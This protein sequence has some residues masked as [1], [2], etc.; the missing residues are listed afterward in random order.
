MKLQTV[1]YTQKTGW[2][3]SFRL[4]AQLDSERTLII[5]FG[6]PSFI[7]EFR[8]FDE[9]R[10]IFPKSIKIGCSGAGEI[11]GAHVIDESLSIAVIK[12]E[13]SNIK[14]ITL[15]IHEMSGSY[16]VGRE[17]ALQLNKPDLAGIFVLSDGLL[18]NGSALVNG[19]NS[20][21]P[22]KITTG[23]LAGDGSRFKE[24]WIVKNGKP[25]FGYVSAVGFYG[26]SIKIGYGSNAGWDIFGPERLVT[27]S[28]G[29]ILYELDG[30]P[31]L[32]LYKEYLGEKVAGLPATAL[33]FPL[34]IRSNE[35]D[36]IKIVRT[37]LAID[38]AHQ[39]MIF[40]GDI[41]EGS[42]AQLMHANFDRLIEGA[43]NT[44]KEIQ[45]EN[46][47]GKYSPSLVIAISCFGRRLVLGERTEEEVESIFNQL[48]SETRQIGFYSYGEISPHGF[49]KS[50]ELH[51]QTMTL[52]LI[53]EDISI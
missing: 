20:V 21:A 29:N 19:I 30:A 11:F 52:T 2:S 5:I 10:Q 12:F 17:L 42:L 24:T 7:S 6:A 27:K 22:D 25:S 1:Q 23:G 8:V 28:E 44:A 37:V 53:S 51:N 32:T 13:K 50:C 15:P 48:P 26:P 43:S 35:K 45:G 40:A 34:Q 16:D 9:I 46:C 31:A 36:P 4:A 18:V 49:S 47:K 14:A 33:L 41:P 39:A 3:E 38:E